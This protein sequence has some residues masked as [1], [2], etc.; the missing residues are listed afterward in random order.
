MTIPEITEISRITI[1]PGDRLIVRVADGLLT[2]AQADL[3]EQRLR[4]RLQLP[5]SVRVAIIVG[6]MDLQVVAE[7]A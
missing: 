1:N 4:A 7:D 2:A 6:G 5:V 3:I